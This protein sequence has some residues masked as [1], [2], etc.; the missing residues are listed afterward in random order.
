MTD[1]PDDRPPQNDLSAGERHVMS[2]FARV[3]LLQS[4]RA[5]AEAERSVK[6]RLA[7][8]ALE[9]ANGQP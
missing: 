9:L 6:R 5:E 3:F 7:G 8:R 2:C 1:G 4:A